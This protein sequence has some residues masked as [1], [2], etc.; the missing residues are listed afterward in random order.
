MVAIPETVYA[1]DAN[2]HHV[3]YQVVGDSGPD[4]LFIPTGSFPIDLLWD[5]PTIG[6]HLRRLASFSRLILTDLLGMGSSDA[7]PI[8]EIPAIQSWTDGLLAVLDAVGS[9]CT[10]V[11]A[12]AQSAL[13]AMLRASCRFSC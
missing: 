7:L 4:L 9:E 5:E 8:N 10:S 11:F 13:P 2:G 1:R 6:G 12:M 3:A